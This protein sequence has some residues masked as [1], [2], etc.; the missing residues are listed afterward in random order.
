MKCLRV[1]KSLGTQLAKETDFD[2]D[3]V[4]FLTEFQAALGY[5]EESGKDLN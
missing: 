3:G 2:A 4:Q 1:Q 5:A